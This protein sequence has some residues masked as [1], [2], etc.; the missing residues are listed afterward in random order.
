M[1]FTELS[2]KF[3][4][5]QILIKSILKKSFLSRE[6]LMQFFE[7]VAT[8]VLLLSYVHGVLSI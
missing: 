6:V 5:L 1:S 7:A 8:R 4:L 3:Y 2:L